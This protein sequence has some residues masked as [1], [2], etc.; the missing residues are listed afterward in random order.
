MRGEDADN[1]ADLFAF[2]AI[3]YEMLTG[4]QAFRG[5]SS[6]EVMNAILKEEPLELAKT[7]QDIAPAL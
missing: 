5:K 3:L 6:V 4:Q 1:R 2:G 7:K